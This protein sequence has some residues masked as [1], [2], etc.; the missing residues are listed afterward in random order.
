MPAGSVI[1]K[2]SVV[3][4]SALS[5]VTVWAKVKPLSEADWPV[6][7]YIGSDSF[8]SIPD[9]PAGGMAELEQAATLE[10]SAA[11]NVRAA[12]H[13]RDAELRFGGVWSRYRPDMPFQCI[14]DGESAVRATPARGSGMISGSGEQNSHSWSAS[15]SAWWDWTVDW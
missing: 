5:V 3:A 9:M 1:L 13:R 4:D 15:P 7:W 10:A 14:C 6:P 2:R 8:M 11:V 12:S